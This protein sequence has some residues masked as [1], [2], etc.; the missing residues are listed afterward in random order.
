MAKKKANGKG[1][2]EEN[3]IK[4]LGKCETFADLEKF[5]KNQPDDKITA[6][7]DKAFLKPH[8]YD[9]LVKLMEKE[10]ERLGSKDFKNK[11][12]IKAHLNYRQNTNKW[13]FQT[14]GDT[15]QL[16]GLEK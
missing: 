1:K 5:I 11:S 4:S 16:I 12:R 13:I 15:V 6:V 2:K 8:T 9:D 7:L 14:E 3:A 10:N